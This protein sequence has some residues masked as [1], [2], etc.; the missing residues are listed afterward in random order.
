MSSFRNQIDEIKSKIK[1]S[2]E[3][4]KHNIK[5]VQKGNDLWSLCFFH[6]EKTPSMKI[7]DDL[8][9][10]YCFGCG[11]KGDLITF[12]TD[13]LNYSF[14]DALKE[15]A[16]KAGIKLNLDNRLKKFDEEKSEKINEIFELASEWFHSNLYLKEN[17]KSLKYLKKR[18]ISE[19][20]IKFF[21][22][23]YSS[24]LN[25]S[26]LDHLKKKSFTEKELLK[27]SLF[28]LAKNNKIRDFFY[29]RLIFPIYN[30]NS[31]VI[32][33]GGRSLDGSEP[34]YINSSESDFFK[35]RNILYNLD[36]A[37]IIARK[38]N[39][40]LIC[41][42]YMD[43][44]SLYDKGI[45]SVVSPLGTALTQEQLIMAWKTCKI[46]TIMFDGDLAGKKASIKSALLALKLLKPGF[47]LQF[48]EMPKDQD[49]D[50]LINNLSKNEF[51]KFLKSPKILS[52]FIFDYAKESFSY[53]TPDEKIVFDKYFDDISNLIENKKVKFFYKNEFKNKLYSFFRNKRSFET[54]GKNQKLDEKIK[55]LAYK[56]LLS[57]IGCYI[58]HPSIRID[59]IEDISNLDYFDQPL[60][61]C[62]KELSKKEKINLS[63]SDLIKSINN[64]KILNVIKKSLNTAIYQLFPYSS[65]DYNSHTALVEIKKSLRIIDTRL[66]NF[67]EL[68]KSIK[69]FKSET[70]LLKWNELKKLSYDYISEIE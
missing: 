7:N 57:F 15:L 21:K 67:I 43:V 36:K 12:Y 25:S 2:E 47:S 49:P 58:N 68:D 52:N 1:I 34:K 16:D 61:D 14:S 35:K 22:I 29:K 5:L 6:N 38:K 39:N 56:E 4:S 10:Y 37:K 51:I 8:S 46:P 9:S 31:K 48:L 59:L 44:I 55:K 40:L 53:Q 19:N 17:I 24:N 62:F 20:T 69:D 18:N 63:S 30:V 65:S 42:G 33:F 28:I 26:L 41:E 60:K 45:K 64:E 50:S 70:T 11:A 54:R 13:Y 66:S 32:G 23:G 27:T 3:I